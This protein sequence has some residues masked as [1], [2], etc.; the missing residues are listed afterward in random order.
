MRKSLLQ[1]IAILIILIFGLAYSSS[2]AQKMERHQHEEEALK[3]LSAPLPSSLDAL[4]P[5]QAEQPIF[6]FRMMEM[7]T[8]FVGIV[9]D[10]FENDLQNAKNNF[11]RFKAQYVD[12]S[13]LVP[14][15]KK[16]YL[17]GPVEE[18]GEVL[19]TGDQDE[20]MAA[21]EKV[22]NICHDCHLVNMVKVQQKFHWQDFRMIKVKD[23]LTDEQVD[24]RLL[25]QYL[26]TNFI[27]ISV[28]TMEGQKENAQKQFQGFKARFQAMKDTCEE[29][30][31]TEERK[32]Y[33]DE[34]VQAMVDEMGK[35]LNKPSVDPKEVE[36]LAQRI[37]MESCFKC[38]LVHL[39]AAYAKHQWEKWE[40]IKGK[41][42]K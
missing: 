39:P 5:P 34:S 29:C 22:G 35:A 32:Y 18:L 10:L 4:Y 23:P 21:Y 42:K 37:G 33:V 20:V 27:G 8:P 6:L 13:K 7:A 26:V 19:K 3:A 2:Q 41:I 40:N 1:S 36:T 16:S 17:L 31:A 30:H 11:E 14:E 24:F 28:D 25:M 38:H 12:V 15:W 9:V